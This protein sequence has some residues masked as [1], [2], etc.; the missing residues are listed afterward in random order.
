[1]SSTYWLSELGLFRMLWIVLLKKQILLFLITAMPSSRDS[2]IY[3]NS[4]YEILVNE[5]F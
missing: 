5:A 2:K 4:F 3:W 1:M